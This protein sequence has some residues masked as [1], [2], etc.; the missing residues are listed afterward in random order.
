MGKANSCKGGDP[1]L[2][3]KLDS[4]PRADGVFQTYQKWINSTN[5]RPNI[6]K[7]ET[8]ALWDLMTA[9]KDDVVAR[10]AVD[11]RKA[12]KWIVENPKEHLTKARL[13]I[14]SNWGTFA[15]ST[16]SAFIMRDM[17]VP[18]PKGTVFSPTKIQWDAQS[19]V[20]SE[21]TIESVPN[22]PWSKLSVTS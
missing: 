6:M 17:S 1:T 14:T 9:G 22:P 7:F 2:S 8:M 3:G 21:I 19:G 4:N 13:I 18:I 11:V 12:Y 10:R 20:Q 5:T 16:P 15:L